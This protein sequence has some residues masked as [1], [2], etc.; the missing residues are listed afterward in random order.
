MT[1]CIFINYHNITGV[2]DSLRL[3][4]GGC[5]LNKESWSFDWFRSMVWVEYFETNWMSEKNTK[6]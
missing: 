1:R 3:E 4:E 5:Q 6:H 2:V